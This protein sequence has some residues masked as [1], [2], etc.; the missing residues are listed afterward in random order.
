VIAAFT[1]PDPICAGASFSFTNLSSG[2]SG[3]FWEFGDGSTST[4]PSPTHTY[5]EPGTYVVRLTSSD[6]N[7]CNGQD[8][9]LRTIVIAPDAPTVIAMN[10]TLVC[11]P[12]NALEVSA[13]G[14]GTATSYVWSTSNTFSDTLNAPELDSTFVLSPI[15]AGT[16][17]VRA[18]NG[19]ICASMDSVVITTSLVNALVQGDTTI[20]AQDTAQLLLLGIDPGSTIVWMPA[21][22]ILTGQG[23]TN[24]TVAPSAS[25]VYGV[26]VVSPSGCTWSSTIGVE[27]SPLVGSTVNATV[28]Q[29]I[30]SPGTTVQLSAWPSD[31]V[32]YSW[33]PAASVSDPTSRTPAATVN[34]T[35][36]FT[37]TVSDG[38]CTRE[39]SVTVE[40]RDLLCEDPDIFVP[41]TFTPNGDGNNDVLLVRGRSI[42]ELEFMVFDRWGEKVFETNDQDRGWDGTFEGKPVDPA[43]FVYHLTVYCVDGQRFFTKGNV[44]IVR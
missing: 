2:A 18:S 22:E 4:L 16:Y 23:S 26:L 19:S 35:T 28:D 37:V 31:G 14:F 3:Y 8:I 32:N 12:N 34:N 29:G 44:T 21:D 9:A 30:V 13:Q 39:A 41:N 25:M 11:G 6:P 17:H 42:R 43:V 15:V 33:S 27:V 38:I 36:T 1:A 20:C 24:A 10:D 40:V 5:S 7:S